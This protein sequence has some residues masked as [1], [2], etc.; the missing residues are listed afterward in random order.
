MLRPWS[1]NFKI[2]LGEILE[3]ILG[4]LALL[5]AK[6]LDAFIF[7][8]MLTQTLDNLLIYPRIS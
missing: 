1:N 5:F 7:K 2:I 3:V 4:K 6:T 8:D